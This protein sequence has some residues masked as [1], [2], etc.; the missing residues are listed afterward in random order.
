YLARR[1]REVS[2]DPR[3]YSALQEWEEVPEPARKSS[4]LEADHLQ[5]KLRAI[6]CT[7]DMERDHGFE[8]TALEAEML[9]NPQISPT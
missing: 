2:A 9:A 6:R 7:F 1:G 8:F 5:V 4:R 3:L